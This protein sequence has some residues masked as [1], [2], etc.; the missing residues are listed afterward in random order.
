MMHPNALLIQK[1]Y[2]AF[3]RLDAQAMVACYAEDIQFSDPV[4]LDLKGQQVGDMWRMLTSRAQDFSLVF[5]QI[6][7]NETEGRAHWVA[8]YCFSQTGR[9]VVNDI[10]AKFTFRDGKIAVHRDHFDLWK[11]SR[12]AM[13][14]KGYLMGRLPLVQNKIRH[15]AEKNLRKFSSK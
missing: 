14:W 3:Q 6:E 2:E 9:Q 11:W 10:H 15:Q 7:A 8:S 12:Q 13:G 5:D 4:F 1:F